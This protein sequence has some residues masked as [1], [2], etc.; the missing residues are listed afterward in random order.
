[1]TTKD[2]WTGVLIFLCVCAVL[3]AIAVPSAITAHENNLKTRANIAACYNNGG[4]WLDY[5]SF[6]LKN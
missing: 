1:M 3:A 2:F 6:C 4:V 5:E